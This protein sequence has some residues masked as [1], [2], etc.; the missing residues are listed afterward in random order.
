MEELGRG[1]S[2]VRGIVCVSLGL[3]GKSIAAYGT[4]EQKQEWLP[5]I[6]SGETLGC[7]GLTEPGTGSDAGNLTTRAVRD[8]DDWLITGEKMFITNGTWAEVA[9][10]FARTGGDGPARGDRVP[11]ARPTRPASRRREIKGKLGLRGQ[12]TASLLLDEVRV[13]D[14]EPARRRGQ[15]LPGRDVRAGQGPD[16][17]RR[18]L[19]RHRPRLPGG[20]RR[21]TRASASSSA[22]RSPATSWCRSCSPTS[23]STWTPPGC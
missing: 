16:G 19:R 21:G 4:E 2:A 6:A 7:F 9:L 10:V 8:G 1:D 18:R 11:G 20:G 5:G 3:V 12:A 23:R 15:G 13:P 14:A 17:G 22:S